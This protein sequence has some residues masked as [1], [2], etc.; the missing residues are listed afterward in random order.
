MIIFRKIVSLPMM[1]GI[2]FAL[3]ENTL[4]LVNNVEYVNYL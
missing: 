3:L 4:I 1:V 2:S